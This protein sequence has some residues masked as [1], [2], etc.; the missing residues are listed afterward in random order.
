MHPADRNQSIPISNIP[1]D[2]A[3]L[4]PLGSPLCVQIDLKKD[5]GSKKIQATESQMIDA[6]PQIIAILKDFSREDKQRILAAANVLIG[7]KP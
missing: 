1:L 3:Y 7:N 5:P 6:L 2:R 4:R